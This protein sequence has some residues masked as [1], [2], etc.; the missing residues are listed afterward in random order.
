MCQYLIKKDLYN[1]YNNPRDNPALVF[2]EKKLYLKLRNN[3]NIR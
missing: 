3:K 2:N 1:D